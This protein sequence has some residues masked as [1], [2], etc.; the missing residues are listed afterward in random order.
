MT[1]ETPRR[2]DRISDQLRAYA[3]GYAEI[4]HHLA[5]WMGLHST[6]AIALT[7]ILAAEDKDEPLSPARLAERI[8]LTSGATTTLINRLEG[9]G[10]LERTR[11]QTDRR[12]VTLRSVP[13]MHDAAEAFFE[14]LKNRVEA[15]YDRYSDDELAQ[16]EKFI[17]DLRG[18]VDEFCQTDVASAE[19]PEPPEA[20]PTV[21]SAG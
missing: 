15:V 3:G 8:S 7:E 4:S 1:G 21:M 17:L 2:R 12:I 18:A 9:R 20:R 11:E 14:P 19:F 6:D 5:R 10:C 16:F 13:A